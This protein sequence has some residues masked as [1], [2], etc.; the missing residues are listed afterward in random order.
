MIKT[1]LLYIGADNLTKKVDRKKLLGVLDEQYEGYTVTPAMGCWRKQ[2]EDS[3]VVTV[4]A[5]DDE[6]KK[7]IS[8]LKYELKQEAI[9]LQEAPELVFF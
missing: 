1:F 2:R 6:I 4:Q 7:V 5:D 3:V 9:G 8:K